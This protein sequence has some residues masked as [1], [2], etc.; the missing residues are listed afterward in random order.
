MDSVFRM[1]WLFFT[2]C[3]L[4]ENLHFP[5]MCIFLMNLLGFQSMKLSFL[6]KEFL[7][8]CFVE[9]KWGCFSW[10]WVSFFLSWLFH[11]KKA[12][13]GALS[14]PQDPGKGCTSKVCDVGSQPW[15][16]HQWMIVYGVFYIYCVCFWYQRNQIW[17][18][19]YDC[20]AL[21]KANDQVQLVFKLVWDIP[22]K[23]RWSS[24]L[25]RWHKF[26]C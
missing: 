20:W 7:F 16:K 12:Q 21:F 22:W 6:Q 13:P 3:L 8:R 24:F 1:N 10:G 2:G 26:A 17:M 4:L 25:V 9:F 18:S 5:G 19:I 11:G 15:C 14:I 23:L